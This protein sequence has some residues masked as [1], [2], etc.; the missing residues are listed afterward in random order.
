[1]SANRSTPLVVG[2][3]ASAGGIEA[4]QD[5]L[6]ALGDSP[7]FAIVFVQHLD[8]NGKSLLSRL[9]R[10]STQLDVVD[11]TGR[12]RV[13]T[14]TIYICPPGGLVELRGE[15]LLLVGDEHDGRQNT[16]IDHFFQ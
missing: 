7:G 11:L 6:K 14:D 5:F 12:T 8:P 10:N 9:L 2:V 13:R 1:M 16:Q 4:F 15:A 3:G